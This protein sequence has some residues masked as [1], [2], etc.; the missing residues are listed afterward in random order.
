MRVWSPV[1]VSVGIGL[2]GL[3]APER[4]EAEPP[5]MD[6]AFA[7][8]GGGDSTLRSVEARRHYQEGNAAMKLHQWPRARDA[9]LAAWKQ[10]P[11]WQVAGSLGEVE[12]E[13]GSYRDAAAHLSLFLREAR[14][15]PVEEMQRVRGWLSRA[16]ARVARVTIAAAPPGA[17]LSIDGF[18]VGRAPFR[19][20]VYLEPGRHVVA[21]RLGA[22]EFTDSVELAAGGSKAVVLRCEPA[23]PAQGAESPSP[24]T[25]AATRQRA[26]V[27]AGAS[28]TVVALGFGA[29]SVALFTAKGRKAKEI[30]EPAAGPNATAEASFKSVA[31]WSFVAAGVVGGAT[32][33]YEITSKRA[34]RPSVKASVVG[35]PAGA[36]AMLQGEF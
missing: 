21:G 15:V 10:R 9:Y 12:L 26:L 34:S 18:A 1:V 36:A 19:D 32:L 27:L 7:D 23:I 3:L 30:H 35:G 2:G 25:P 4:A 8:G 17:D 5:A 13:L 29:A 6:A 33:A 20:E 11:H 31:L 22:C 24:A 28:V 14:D 16:Q